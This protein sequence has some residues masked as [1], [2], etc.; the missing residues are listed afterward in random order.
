MA[1]HDV[2]FAD[3]H[4]EMVGHELADGIVGLVVNRGGYNADDEAARSIPAHLVPA[5]A[6]DHSY[7][8]TFVVDAHGPRPYVPVASHAT[9]VT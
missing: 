7:F 1:A 4:A 5:S 2:N 6:G 9:T 8:E 3:A